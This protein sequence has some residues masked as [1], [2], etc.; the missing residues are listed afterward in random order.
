MSQL[1]GLLV[2]IGVGGTLGLALI[3]TGVVL[4]FRQSAR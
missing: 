1:T 4:F 2:F 3:V